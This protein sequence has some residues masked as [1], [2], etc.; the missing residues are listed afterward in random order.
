MFINEQCSGG[1]SN[2][3]FCVAFREMDNFCTQLW[4][5]ELA[6]DFVRAFCAH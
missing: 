5:A 3:F 4:P 1:L 2:D 6:L